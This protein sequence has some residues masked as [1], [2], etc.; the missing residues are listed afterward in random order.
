MSEIQLDKKAY[1]K[2]IA[3]DIAALDKHMPKHSLELWHIKDVLKWSVEKLFPE[4]KK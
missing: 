1:E 2:L 4:P 3:E